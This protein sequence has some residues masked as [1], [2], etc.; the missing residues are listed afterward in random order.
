ML[1]STEELESLGICACGRDWKDVCR[2]DESRDMFQE[3]D[4]EDRQDRL[5][6]IVQ[7]GSFGNH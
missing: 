5:S 6:E 1:I 2:C 4:F 7:G 3:E